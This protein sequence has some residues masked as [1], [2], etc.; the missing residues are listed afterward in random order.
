MG[1]SPA[2]VLLITFT[3]LLAGM[4]KGVIGRGLPKVAMGLL[5]LVIPPVQAAGLLVI[6]SLFT[7][8]WQLIVGLSFIALLKRFGTMMIVVGPGYRRSQGATGVSI[9][10][11][12]GLPLANNGRCRVV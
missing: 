2:T 6:P 4:V 1:D 3:F 8:V 11:T 10:M 5:A 9:D 7:N 12:S